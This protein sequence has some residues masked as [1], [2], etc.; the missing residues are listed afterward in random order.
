MLQLRPR[1]IAIIFFF[2]YWYF[3]YWFF[4]HWF[5]FYWFW[6]LGDGEFSS[7]SGW[8]CVCSFPGSYYVVGVFV[9]LKESGRGSL[10][11]CSKVS[12]LGRHSKGTWCSMESEP[13][14]EGSSFRVVLLRGSLISSLPPLLLPTLHWSSL[15]SYIA[16]FVSFV[17]KFT[18]P[19][20]SFTSIFLAFF[21]FEP[22]SK[23][24]L[25]FPAALTERQRRRLVGNSLNVLVVAELI[26]FMLNRE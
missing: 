12:S 18:F 26:K 25:R 17:M 10:R 9:I 11:F 4:F 2:F 23:S 24:G 19:F 1:F 21:L 8:V 6:F 7:I 20:Y 14:L 22:L 15:F 5:F 13:H 16:I 3:F